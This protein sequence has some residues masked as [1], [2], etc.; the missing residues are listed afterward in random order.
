MPQHLKWPQINHPWTN[1]AHDG[2]YLLSLR[3]GVT[4]RW[5]T[6][7]TLLRFTIPAMIEPVDGIRKKITAL[8]AG[9]HSTMTFAAVIPHHE[10]KCVFL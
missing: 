7:A 10:T 3:I 9:L 4:V 8:G 2:A 1:I 6:Q 5:A